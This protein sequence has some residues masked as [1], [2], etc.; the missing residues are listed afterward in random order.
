MADSRIELSGQFKIRDTCN[1][2]IAHGAPVR[3]LVK[4]STKELAARAKAILVAEGGT[5]KRVAIKTQYGKLDGYVVMQVK[6]F[7]HKSA[8]AGLNPALA[9]EFGHNGFIDPRDSQLW[10]GAD[11]KFILTKTLYG[12]S[13]ALTARGRPRRKSAPTANKRIPGGGR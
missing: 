10:G 2:R 13:S 11:G 4:A 12:G 5:G 3:A 8:S 9:V 6:S 7:G 1:D